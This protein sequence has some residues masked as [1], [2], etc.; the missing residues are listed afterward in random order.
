MG[1]ARRKEEEPLRQ[2]T[3]DIFGCR[4]SPFN[5]FVMYRKMCDMFL[6]SDNTVRCLLLTYCEIAAS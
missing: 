5:D 1:R 4:T 3:D 6:S 2:K